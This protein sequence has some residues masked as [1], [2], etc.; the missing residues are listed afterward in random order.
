MPRILSEAARWR[1]Q[2]AGHK[3]SGRPRVLHA[4]DV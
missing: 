1:A 2:S 4:V 3:P